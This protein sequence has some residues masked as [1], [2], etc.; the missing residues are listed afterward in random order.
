MTEKKIFKAKEEERLDIF[1]V[2]ELN[3]SRSQINHLIKKD[4]VFI[5]K[6]PI[7]KQG[8]TL[9]VGDI[10]EVLFKPINEI[11][12]KTNIKI[13]ILYEDKSI[14]VLNK[15]P[16]LVVHR[17]SSVKEETLVDWLEAKGFCLS[18]IDS[19][20]RPGIV[21]RLDK[22]TS[23]AI[24][25][26]KTNEAHKKISKMLEEK[27]VGRYYLAII[28]PPLK[29][30]ICIEKNIAR[31]STN[32]LK[33][34]V[35]KKGRYAK[36]NFAKLYISNKKK[37][38][39]IAAKLFT[40]RTHQIRVH[41]NSINRYILGDD[42]YGFKGNKDIVNRVFLHAF[43][44]YLKHPISGDNL[45]IKAP[46]FDDM[47]DYIIRNFEMENINES[48]SVHKIKYACNFT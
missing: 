15:P 16:K 30:N 3:E 28:N 9:K 45:E 23:G 11:R 19:Q 4:F 10:V 39:L 20:E 46:L 17:A 32:R 6:K 35:S 5:N 7:K 18:T 12:K 37:E 21:H 42:L 40:G 29:N 1:L 14:L 31:N 38:E 33:M 22:G 2:K 27:L 43:C 8:K 36:T 34:E 26:A 24:L 44:L 25:I 13:D 47:Q 48:I 41:L